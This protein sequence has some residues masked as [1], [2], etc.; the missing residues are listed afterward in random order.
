MSDR[1]RWKFERDAER[2]D[3]LTDMGAQPDRVENDERSTGEREVLGVME[4]AMFLGLSRN[5]VR[6]YADR[7]TIPHRRLGRKLLFS[8]SALVRWLGAMP[9]KG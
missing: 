4:A 8:R 3:R 2:A 5:T 1:A 9:G 6:D 7:G